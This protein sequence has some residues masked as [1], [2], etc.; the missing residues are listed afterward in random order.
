MVGVYVQASQCDSHPTDASVHVC[1]SV[2]GH[3]SVCVSV[4]GQIQPEP[5]RERRD[6]RGLP[7]LFLASLA[8]I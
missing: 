2:S 4:L 1:S 6:V 7:A 8:Q 3:M 5:N